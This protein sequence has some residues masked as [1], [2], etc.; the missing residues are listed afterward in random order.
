M[1]FLSN[2]LE[3]KRGLVC[4]YCHMR[5]TTGANGLLDK[6]LIEAWH[7]ETGFGGSASY[8]KWA[9]THRADDCGKTFK[10]VTEVKG[11]RGGY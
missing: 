2:Y 11:H 7:E 6:E 10:K 4:P 9:Y 5:A 3:T 8:K 1:G